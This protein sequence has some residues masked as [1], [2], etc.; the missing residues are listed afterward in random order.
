MTTAKTSNTTNV[1]ARAIYNR[2]GLEANNL[3]ITGKVASIQN[4]FSDKS[5]SKR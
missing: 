2:I 5:T 4:N 3:V 1:N